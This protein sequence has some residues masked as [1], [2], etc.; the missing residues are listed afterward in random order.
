M[1]LD[2]TLPDYAELVDT[3]VGERISIEADMVIAHLPMCIRMSHAL[4][5]KRSTG[6]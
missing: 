3:M 1:E 4:Q 5:K 2:I 6:R